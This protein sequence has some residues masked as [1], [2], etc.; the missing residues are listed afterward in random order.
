MDV[1]IHHSEEGMGDQLHPH[2]WH[3]LGQASEHKPGWHIL[4]RNHHV[5][6][7]SI[8]WAALSFEYHKTKQEL[9]LC[10]EKKVCVCVCVWGVECTL[11]SGYW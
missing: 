10:H 2:D 5:S 4:D 9:S 3:Q 1:S 7:R 8:L 6:G 11:T